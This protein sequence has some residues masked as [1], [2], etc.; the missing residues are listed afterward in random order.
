[1]VKNGGIF[2]MFSG[3]VPAALIIYVKKYINKELKISIMALFYL[4]LP[5]WLKGNLT[6][7]ASCKNSTES[8]IFAS[9]EKWVCIKI[10]IKMKLWPS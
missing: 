6:L 10:S 4:Q 1:M 9:G 5:F 2:V 3:L 7:D 8:Q